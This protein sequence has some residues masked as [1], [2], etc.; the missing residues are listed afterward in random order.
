MVRNLLK[1]V[2][3]GEEYI[4]NMLALVRNIYIIY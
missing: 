3:N 4:H 2:R 1:L